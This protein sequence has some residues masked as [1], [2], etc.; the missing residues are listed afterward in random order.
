MKRS[1]LLAAF[2]LGI[3]INCS[4]QPKIRMY[5][6]V[7]KTTDG[8]VGGIFEKANDQS[9]NLTNRNNQN[10]T[11]P[12]SSIRRLK[13]KE[14]PRKFQKMVSLDNQRAFLCMMKTVD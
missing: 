11:I 14:F 3:L 9:V 6:I 13:I 2:V 7:V 8:R 4:A 12:V 1:L 5:W 10:L